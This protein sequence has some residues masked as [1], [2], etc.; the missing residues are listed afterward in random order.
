MKA[1]DTDMSTDGKTTQRNQLG[2][3]YMEKKPSV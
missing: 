1:N 3:Q 2:L